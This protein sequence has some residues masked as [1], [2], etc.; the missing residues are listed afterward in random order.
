MSE[1]PLPGIEC[2]KIQ[3]IH[4]EVYPVEKINQA[5]RPYPLGIDTEIAFRVDVPHPLREY[6]HFR[7][8]K[9]RVNWS[10]YLPPVFDSSR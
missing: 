7:S 6:I 10:A 2:K 4:I 1:D 5:I 3:P 9:A 8:I